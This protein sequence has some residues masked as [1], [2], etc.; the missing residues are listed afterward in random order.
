MEYRA[1]HYSKEDYSQAMQISISDDP[2]ILMNED[3]Y[4]WEDNPSYWEAL[5]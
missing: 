4:E 3:G 2:F 1:T 5:A